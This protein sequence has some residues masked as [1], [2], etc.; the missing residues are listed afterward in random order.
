MGLYIN[1]H[2]ITKERF[3]N[4]FAENI[5]E[6]EKYDPAD[7]TDKVLVCLVDNGLFT[8]AAVCT[9][10]WDF[11]CFI[12]PQDLRDKTYWS[13]KRD[14]LKLVCTKDSLKG[15]LKMDVEDDDFFTGD[16]EEL[17]QQQKEANDE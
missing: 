7:W 2:G 10:E 5:D 13:L 12:S 6:P 9:G 11:K 14:Y 8:A 4:N 17:L 15:Y 16:W 3:L 1:P